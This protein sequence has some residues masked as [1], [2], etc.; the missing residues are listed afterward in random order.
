MINSFSFKNHF[1]STLKKQYRKLYGFDAARDQLREFDLLLSTQI[2]NALNKKGKS[3]AIKE[4]EIDHEIP[5]D[6]FSLSTLEYSDLEPIEN[7]SY[8]PSMIE[9][10]Q[11]Y[12]NDLYEDS[13][14]FIF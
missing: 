3:K 5:S 10:E 1:Y 4:K 13:E 14:I 9:I 11:D 2:L 7:N 8:T 12:H 6:N